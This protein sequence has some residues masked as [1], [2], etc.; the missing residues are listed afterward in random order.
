[1]TPWLREWR[2]ATRPARTGAAAHGDRTCA[3]AKPSAM[4]PGRRVLLRADDRLH[5][6]L[7]PQRGAPEDE[8]GPG[9]GPGAGRRRARRVLRLF[10]LPGGKAVDRFR[11]K[12]VS[13]IT[14]AGRGLFTAL[15]AATQPRAADPRPA[16]PR[17]R[18]GRWL[19]VQRRG[20]VARVPEARASVRHVDIR[21][22]HADGDRGR[23]S[24]GR[25]ADRVDRVAGIVRPDRG[26]RP[27]MGGRSG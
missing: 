21:Q 19:P 18:R 17:C 20:G 5:R 24:D 2:G 7:E 11:E 25:R 3:S 26:A 13:A 16:R 15:T 27:G 10:Q 4:V 9:A 8:D 12:I 14:V 1:M 23:A 22:R 6:P